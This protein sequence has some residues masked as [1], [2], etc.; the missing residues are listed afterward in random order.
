MAT[1]NMFIRK[2]DDYNYDN[3]NLILTIRF[4]SGATRKYHDIPQKIFQGLDAA[5]DKNE[6]YREQIDGRFRIE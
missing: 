3:E 5:P 2:I 6:F 1:N 4:H